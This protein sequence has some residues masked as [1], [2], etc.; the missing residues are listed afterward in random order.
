MLPMLAW[1]YGV[2]PVLPPACRFHPS[3]SE[4]GLEAVRRHGAA[5]GLWL[6]AARIG[7]CHPWSDGGV[8][9]VP[10]AVDGPGA[11]LGRLIRRPDPV[12]AATETK[13]APH[14]PTR[15]PRDGRLPSPHRT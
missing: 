4:Y 3:C 2:S 6:A 11:Y 13:H 1:R 14:D 5:R 8:D 7:R 15:D 9:P 12:A 10:D